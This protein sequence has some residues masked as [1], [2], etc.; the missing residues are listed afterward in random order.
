MKFDK[1]VWVSSVR[2]PEKFKDF[3]DRFLS[4]FGITVYE[5]YPYIWR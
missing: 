4:A 3:Q 2:Y 1:T 5:I